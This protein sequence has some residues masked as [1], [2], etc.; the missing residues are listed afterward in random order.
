MKWRGRMIKLGVVLGLVVIF[1]LTPLFPFLRSLVVMGLYS[2][3][4]KQKSLL[5]DAGIELKVP[6]GLTTGAPDWYPFP[7]VF[8]ADAAYAAYTG[9]PDARLTILYSFP[10]YDL[11]RGCS[12]LFDP[13]SD[14][15]NAFY[16]AY[17]VRDGTE[18]TEQ[19]V[20]DIARFDF[21]SLVLE[22]F[23]LTADQEVFDF[24]VTDRRTGVDYAG[25]A[26]WTRYAAEFTVNGAAHNIQKGVRSYLQYGEPNFG[27]VEAPFAPVEMHGLVYG[28]YF[29]DQDVG[30]YFYVMAPGEDVCLA[31][32]AHILSKSTLEM[33]K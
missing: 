14:Y 32:D 21:F 18:P 15:Y 31:C 3:Y 24:T 7:M 33:K 5:S 13:V 29:P 1:V 22:D 20:A 28:K 16:G 4:N 6:G 2:P 19:A 17:V 30:V 11:T 26:G 10:A 27:H 8:D 23:G 9:R 12:Y 25:S